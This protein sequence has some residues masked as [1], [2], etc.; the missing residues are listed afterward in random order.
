[1]N[2]KSAIRFNIKDNTAFYRLIAGIGAVALIAIGCIIVLKPFFPAMLLAVIF[3]LSTWPAFDWLLK[4]MENRI[5]LA[6]SLMTLLLAL[7]FVVPLFIIGTSIADNY[8]K[9]YSTVQ[10]TLTSNPEGT[11]EQLGALPYVG[12]YAQDFW[13]TTLSDRAK[14]SAWLKNYTNEI[15]QNLLKLGTSIGYGLFDITL[16][17]II[18]FFLFRYG[19]DTAART[20]TLIEKFGGPYGPRL[21]HICKNTLIGVVYGL[22]GT[23]LA[24]G[25][26][27]SIG[28]WIA[29][30]PGASFLGLMTFFFSIIPMGPPLIWIP[31]VI[32]LVSQ[33]MTYKAIFLGIWGAVVIG[34]VDNFMKPY[35]ISRGS[36]LPLL[37]VL[38]GIMGGVLAFG[39]IGVFIGPTLL[40]LAYSLL[41]EWSNVRS[42]SANTPEI[43][44]KENT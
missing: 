7:C 40:A 15:S 1:M 14:I 16:G 5:T 27:A 13:E 29:D 20:H 37:L 28:F 41:L 17:V 21:L 2:M 35:F 25:A 12:S 6:S 4:K 10:E 30:V 33:G 32:W 42:Q 44:K 34:S 38:L 8:D 19:T 9:I 22:F 24:Q 31:A 18:A 23:A 11:S 43:P 36:N 39:F 26:L 3:A